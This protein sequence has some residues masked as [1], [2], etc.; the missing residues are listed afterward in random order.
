MRRACGV[1]YVVML[2]RSPDRLRRGCAN[3]WSCY[4]CAVCDMWSCYANIAHRTE[5]VGCLARPTPSLTRR[6]TGIQEGIYPACISTAFRTSHN[7][8]SRV[9]GDPTQPAAC[10]RRMKRSASNPLPPHACSLGIQHAGPRFLSGFL[11]R[12]LDSV[13]EG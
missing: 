4:A 7:N 1:R 6:I 11:P 3:M 12:K 8:S 2:C 13:S 9:I 10:V 5:R